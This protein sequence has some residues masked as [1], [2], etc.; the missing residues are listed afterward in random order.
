MLF[1][2]LYTDFNKK[3][4]PTKRCANFQFVSNLAYGFWSGLFVKVWLYIVSFTA[5]DFQ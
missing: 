2:L 1:P 5:M 4:H 3:V